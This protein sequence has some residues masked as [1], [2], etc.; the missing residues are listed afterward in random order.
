MAIPSDPVRPNPR[1]DRAF[2]LDRGARAPDRPPPRAPRRVG[3]P[4]GRSLPPPP[5][6]GVPCPFRGR[7]PE[8]VDLREP[9]DDGGV[10][11]PTLDDDP[12]ELAAH[13]SLPRGRGPRGRGR[14]ELLRPEGREPPPVLRDGGP[15]VRPRPEVRD[16][17]GTRGPVV[18]HPEL[19]RRRRERMGDRRVPHGVPP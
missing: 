10:L 7:V 19:R 3:A 12:G 6:R 1:S 17:R 5:L 14:V 13:L 16:G 4:R 11:G 2:R 8:L 18:L 9:R 15:R